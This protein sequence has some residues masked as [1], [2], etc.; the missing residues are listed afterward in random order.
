M[1]LPMKL[2]I[3][4]V[5]LFAAVFSPGCVSMGEYFKDRANDLVDPFLFRVS[6]G[7][8]VST[9]VQGTR[10][11]P[12]TAIG[13]SDSKKYGFVGRNYTY[14]EEECVGLGIFGCRSVRW[15]KGSKA[16]LPDHLGMPV[17]DL[18]VESVYICGLNNIL[19]INLLHTIRSD[20][21]N[22]RKEAIK[23]REELAHLF[24][25]PE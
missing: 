1:K 7:V 9:L 14:S 6:Y 5:L 20:A 10:F 21:E 12:G 15:Q 16:Y 2:G 13:L 17:K 19:F 24:T 18:D 3:F 4:V 8:G 22:P 25:I 11:G 23:D